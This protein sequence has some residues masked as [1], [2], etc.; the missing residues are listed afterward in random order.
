V[1]GS[2]AGTVL[3]GGRTH[4]HRATQARRY[5]LR[6]AGRAGSSQR[7]NAA[8]FGEACDALRRSVGVRSWRVSMTRFDPDDDHGSYDRT[9]ATLLLLFFDY[10]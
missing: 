2:P 10:D 9:I 8:S 1:G 7:H 3:C 4:P 5:V 6:V